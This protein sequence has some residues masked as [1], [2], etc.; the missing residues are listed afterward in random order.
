MLNEERCLLNYG[1]SFEW[2]P[3]HFIL[4]VSSTYL[5]ARDPASG[6]NYSS[7]MRS[8]PPTWASVVQQPTSR[9]LQVCVAADLLFQFS[10]SKDRQMM[11]SNQT[12]SSSCSSSGFVGRLSFVQLLYSSSV[13]IVQASCH[14]LR[15]QLFPLGL[16]KGFSGII[17]GCK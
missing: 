13:P 9:I 1:I 14:N 12:S 10:S 6:L 3:S 11:H 5:A 8:D 17:S 4:Q 16:L 15:R 7:T 2:I